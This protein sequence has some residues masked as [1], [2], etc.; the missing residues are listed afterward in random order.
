MWLK[1]ACADERKFE[2]AAKLL[3]RQVA[4]VVEKS[5]FHFALHRKAAEAEHLLYCI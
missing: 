5:S 3:I 2:A 4:E 1:G